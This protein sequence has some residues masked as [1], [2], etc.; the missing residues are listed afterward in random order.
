MRRVTKRLGR[1]GRHVKRMCARRGRRRRKAKREESVQTRCSKVGA[2]RQAGKDLE[3]AGKMSVEDAL[4]K[5]T[6]TP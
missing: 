5:I 6:S 1:R 2:G 4:Q 3:D